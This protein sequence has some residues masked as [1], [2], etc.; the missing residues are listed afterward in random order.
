[1]KFAVVG[2]SGSEIRLRGLIR[3]TKAIDEIFTRSAA[4]ETTSDV[5]G[6]LFAMGLF[7]CFQGRVICIMVNA[8]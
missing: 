3:L 5:R 7:M 4:L 1:M 2:V 8:I 6:N